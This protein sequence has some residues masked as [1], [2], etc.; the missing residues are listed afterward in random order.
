MFDALLTRT[1]TEELTIVETSLSCSLRD[2]KSWVSGGARCSERL[3][4]ALEDREVC[5]VSERVT[6]EQQVTTE[7]VER[8]R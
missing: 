7:P 6:E 5:V 2:M 4:E 8:K 3:S 1:T